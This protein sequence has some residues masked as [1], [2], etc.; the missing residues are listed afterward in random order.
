MFK[1][2]CG[3]SLACKTRSPNIASAVLE[4][5]DYAAAHL[6]LRHALELGGAWEESTAEFREV[7][8]LRPDNA[9]AQA[10]LRRLAQTKTG[11]AAL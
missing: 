6:Y 2:F 1:L 4:K 5:S 10:E 9:E 7:L 11:R 3:D 8:E